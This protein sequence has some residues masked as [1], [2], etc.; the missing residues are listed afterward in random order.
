MLFVLREYLQDYVSALNVLRYVPFRVVAS[1]VTGLMITWILYPWFIK[2]LQM[3]QIGQTIREDGP[4]SHLEKAG[5]P[6]MGGTLMVIAILSAILLWADLTNI[7][8]LM[9]AFIMLGYA[10]LGFVDDRMKLMRGG[11]KGVRGKT[12]LLWQFL[13]S[14]VMLSFFFYVLAPD[15]GYN[16]R[17]YFP[18]FRIDR[19]WIELPPWLYVLFGSFVIAGFSNAVNLTDGLD[20]LAILPT[21]SASATFLLLAYVGGATFFGISLSKYLLIP[22]IPGIAELSVV[23][24]AVIGAGFGFL[25]YNSYPASIF[26]GDVGSLALGGGLGCMA[27]FTKNELLSLVIMGIFVLEVISVITQ[28]VSFKLTGKRVFRMAPIHHHYELKG[29]SEPKIISR[30]WIVSVLLGLIALASLKLR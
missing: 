30:F 21:I 17:L 28:T 23:A 20:G 8:V 22:S 6:T 2:V 24:G 16:M 1:I 14:I 5:T 18:F 13:L 15:S 10:I 27:L 4:Q 12:K 7:Y 29:L 11:G 9:T 26:M 25:W 3:K 19:Y